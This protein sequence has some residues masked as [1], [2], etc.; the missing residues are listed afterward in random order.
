MAAQSYYFK[1]PKTSVLGGLGSPIRA[2]MPVSS[3]QQKTIYDYIYNKQAT[4]TASAPTSNSG[5]GSAGGAPA[6]QPNF[7]VFRGARY[8]L[9]NPSQAQ[10]FLSARNAALDEQVQEYTN[11]VNQQLGYDISDAE[12][13]FGKS[14][15]EY[16]RMLSEL[17]LQR[18]DYL[19][20][21]NTSLA[22]LGEGFNVGN[23]KRAGYF[24]KSSPQAFQSS[25]LASGQFALDK[26]NQAQAEKAREK[27]RNLNLFS[28][29]ETSLGQDL[30]DLELDY[31]TY[32][33]RRRAQAANALT[34]ARQ[35]AN[36]SRDTYATELA[37][38]GGVGANLF[39][40]STNQY[41]PVTP[42]QVDLS[43]Y[44][45]YTNFNQLAQ[46]PMANIFRKNIDT[47]K[48]QATNPQN[49]LYGTPLDYE[50]MGLGQY[51]Y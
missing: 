13:Q 11:T 36:T 46:S 49:Y 28:T 12:R 38:M 27:E 35:Q 40:A 42:T 15:S 21:Y 24:S 30:S 32:L 5:G 39:R 8:D 1:N 17:G 33:D 50:K 7:I 43:P 16:D 45:Q 14:K 31:N 25:E 51:L 9:N 48:Q 10:A 44:T 20:D 4:P 22:D 34:S 3:K 37:N 19:S 6:Y 26:Y 2:K 18:S 23:I 41:A 29:Q 47:S